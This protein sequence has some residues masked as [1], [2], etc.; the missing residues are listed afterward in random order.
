M[1]VLSLVLVAA[2]VFAMPLLADDGQEQYGKQLTLKKTTKIADLLANPKEYEGK[3]VLVEGKITDVCSMMGCWIMIQDDE[4][5]EPIQFKVDDGVIEFPM[6]VKGKKALAEGV[7]SVKTYT[8]DELIKQARHMAEE[9]G[10]GDKFD[11]STIKGPKTVVRIM[12]EGALVG[13]GE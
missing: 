12:G 4:A 13:N 9:K 2:L 5:V 1:K 7:V 6:E 11:P 10:E 3:K 8:Q